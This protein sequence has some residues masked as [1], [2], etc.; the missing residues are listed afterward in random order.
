MSIKAITAIAICLYVLLHMNEHCCFAEE[1]T[2][3]K[4]PSAH[5]KIYYFQHRLL[6]QWTHESEGAFFDDLMHDRLDRLTRA[7]LEIVGED[8]SRRI[9]F[10]KYP[11]SNGILL[12]FVAPAEA[13]ECFFIYI[14]KTEAGF[15]FYTYEKTIDLFGTGV[16]GVLGAWSKDKVHSN[17]GP[18]TYEDTNSFAAELQKSH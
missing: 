12:T 7:A 5:D 11:E 13:P 17:L 10:R 6:P 8:F 14:A 15:Q 3:P 1:V 9:Q 16:K 2:S 18:R 4:P